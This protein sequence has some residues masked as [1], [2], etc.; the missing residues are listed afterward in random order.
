[1]K[2]NISHIFVVS[3]LA[4]LAI[5]G[6]SCT[7]SH[8]GPNDHDHPHGHH[9]ED[10]EFTVPE[11]KNRG[12]AL[13]SNQEMDMIQGRYE[14]AKAT[15][16]EN[17][18]SVDALI[19]LTQ[20]FIT[21]G[22]ITGDQHYY[23]DAALA[24]IAQVKHN[25]IATTD[26]QFQA[27]WLE[28][29]VLMTMHQFAKAKKVATKA[30]MLN[31]Y[32]AAVYGVLVDANVELGNYTEAVEVADKMV[33]IRPDLRSYSR[34]SYLREIHG[35]AE[36][37]IEAMKMA[38]E[39]GYPGDEQRAW[40]RVKLGQLQ[41]TYSDLAEAE[42]Q[43]LLAIQERDDY[44]FALNAL[45]NVKRKQGSFEEAEALAER[46][47]ALMENAGF[48]EILA[49]IQKDQGKDQEAAASIDKC[50]ELLIGLNDEE[51]AHSH[52]HGTEHTHTH[53]VSLE[54]A[55]VQLRYKNDVKKALKSVKTEYNNRPNNIDVNISYAGVL[56]RKG[57]FKD[58]QKHINKVLEV[59]SKNPDALSLAGLIQMKL[60]AES[61]KDLIVESFQTNP[62]QNHAMADEAK[63]MIN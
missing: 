27:L 49:D 42:M 18:T 21:E 30:V 25:E 58:A 37:A 35:D 24:T 55:N 43:Y 23:A 39:A 46:S 5:F 60:G 13:G 48:Y 40:C 53:E 17:K 10:A 31:P 41:E 22:R 45:A 54:M 4:V 32:N 34:I 29:T 56:Y 15:Y 11:L 36:G 26:Q 57:D 12:V 62:Y 14:S 3:G 33:G 1:M 61:G 28:S 16:A 59:G 44:P 9:H 38:V 51:H 19:D 63:A 2:I 7:H 50:I 52:S 6:Q 8:A 20:V 47:I